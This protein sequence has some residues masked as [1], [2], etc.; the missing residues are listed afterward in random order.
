MLLKE[1][2][3]LI[4][5]NDVDRKIMYARTIAVVV[6]LCFAMLLPNVAYLCWWKTNAKWKRIE[7]VEISFYVCFSHLASL[8]MWDLNLNRDL[9]YAFVLYFCSFAWCSFVWLFIKLS[10]K[11]Y[12]SC[13]AT[14]NICR[15]SY[16]CV[17]IWW[18]V[19]RTFFWQNQQKC[20]GN[21]D[22]DFLPT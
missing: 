10:F 20:N 11:L 18:P 4:K 16:V 12:Y 22:V 1:T 13:I 21:V 7:F 9:F 6:F 8:Q 15:Y 2:I 5:W 19:L 17:N 3:I 14:M